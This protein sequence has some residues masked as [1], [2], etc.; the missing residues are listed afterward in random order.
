MSEVQLKP[1]PFCGGRAQQVFQMVGCLKC[2][3]AAKTVEHWDRRTGFDEEGQSQSS[4]VSVG[5]RKKERAAPSALVMAMIDSLIANPQ[6]GALEPTCSWIKSQQEQLG[7]YYARLGL[8]RQTQ[9]VVLITVFHNIQET[10]AA[11]GIDRQF[12]IERREQLLRDA[13]QPDRSGR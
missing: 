10:C 4:G 8:S 7:E 13:P 5:D 3:I 1:C 11:L 9:N 2:D 6:F 12:L